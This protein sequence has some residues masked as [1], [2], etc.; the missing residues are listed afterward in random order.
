MGLR[1]ARATYFYS[2]QEQAGWLNN[3]QAMELPEELVIQLNEP[4]KLLYDLATRRLEVQLG[5][6]LT[7]E[8]VIRNLCESYF[9][10]K[11]EP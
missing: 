4:Q 5:R 3:P 8:E 6:A 10:R 1:R 9:A 11:A 7:P 2:R